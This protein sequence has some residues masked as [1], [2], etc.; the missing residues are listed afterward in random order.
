MIDR[1]NNKILRKQAILKKTTLFLETWIEYFKPVASE[2]SEFDIRQKD[3]IDIIFGRSSFQSKEQ[4]F[5]IN[6]SFNRAIPSI[7]TL[8]EEFKAVVIKMD[9]LEYRDVTTLTALFAPFE[10][11]IPRQKTNFFLKKSTLP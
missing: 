2:K 1:T 7:Q 8:T 11:P 5:S 3:N 9:E 6:D 10:G 4:A